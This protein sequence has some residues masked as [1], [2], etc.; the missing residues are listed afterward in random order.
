MTFYFPSLSTDG[1]ITDPQQIADNMLAHFI[2]SEHSQTQLYGDSIASYAW[3]VA[4]SQ[5]NI[6]DTIKIMER[7]LKQYYS[8]CFSAVEVTVSDISENKD[9]SRVTLGIYLNYTDDK[10]IQHNLA[11]SIQ[12]MNGKAMVIMSINKG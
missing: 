12:E 9:S 3:C 7:T 4:Q 1:W 8:T 11:K 10:G 6:S 5:G 2:T